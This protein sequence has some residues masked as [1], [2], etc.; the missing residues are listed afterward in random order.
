MSS[1]AVVFPYK[2]DLSGIF[3][4]VK[5]PVAVVEFQSKQTGVWHEISMIVDTGADYTLLPRSIAKRLGIDLENDCKIEY[6]SGVGGRERVFMLPEI[7]TRLGKWERKVPVGFLERD[8]IPPLFGR[9]K[10]L[11]S[12]SVT[13]ANFKT[14]FSS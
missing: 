14:S 9:H 5:R 2:D 13:F 3:G 6:T 12:F 8:N 10:F 7:N 4:T 1:K 11:D